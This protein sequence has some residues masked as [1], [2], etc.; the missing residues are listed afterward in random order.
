VPHQHHF[1]SRLDR[2]SADH[3][4]LA[5]SL[6]NDPK[7]V[8]WVLGEARV[9]EAADRVAIS[10]DH[11]HE[12]PF[13]LVTREGRFVTCLGPGMR[14]GDRPI[15]TREKLDATIAQATDYR[16]R[17]AA[18]TDLARGGGAP[19]L[20][21]RMVDAADDLSREEFVAIS[22][23]QPLYPFRLFKMLI[24]A[25][26][27]LDDARQRL[28]PLLPK[29]GKLAPRHA[30][31]ART[32]WKRFWALGHLTVLTTMG[33]WG[34]IEGALGDLADEVLD[35]SLT[36]SAVRQGV[37]ALGLKGAWASARL[38]KVL[39]PGS[40][41]R[42]A[43]AATELTMLDAG[44]ALAAIGRRHSRLRAEADKALASGPAVGLDEATVALPLALARVLRTVLDAPAEEVHA[45]HRAIGAKVA[46]QLAAGLPKGSAYRFEH[47]SDVPEALALTLAVNLHHNYLDDP[48]SA[49]AMFLCLPWIAR[50]AA[51]D[52]YLPRDFIQATR[53][54]WAPKQTY[55]LLGA[56]K[57]HY[58]RAEPPRDPAAPTRK[59]PCPC[60]SGEKYKRCCGA[61]EG[62]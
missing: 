27:D 42:F 2:V 10:L 30:H 18:A 52:L 39:L 15:I 40:K 19:R 34:P 7:L 50:A 38:G 16:A 25:G 58:H 51:K 31:A 20:L 28:L 48:Q 1:L 61:S 46:M 49:T 35:M 55:A 17:F 54:P 36:W 26:V 56:H 57:A 6:Y 12:G 43:A 11:P 41:Q 37:M 8:R 29:S 59:G 33:G 53:A 22:A 4:E 60:G 44:M 14:V 32:Y 45:T 5:L 3:V 47:E 9:P 13:L 24:R 62:P 23:L 21:D